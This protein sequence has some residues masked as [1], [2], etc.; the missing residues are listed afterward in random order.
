MVEYFNVMINNGRHILDDASITSY[1][2]NG[3]NDFNVMNIKTTNE[4]LKSLE[5]LT[6]V[7]RPQTMA[8]S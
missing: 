3:L 4:L 2:I 1:V 8:Q 6:A 7:L 5:N